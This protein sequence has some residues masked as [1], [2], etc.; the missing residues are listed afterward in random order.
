[1]MNDMVNGI[2]DGLKAGLAVAWMIAAMTLVA[3][4]VF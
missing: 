3:W 2:W 1:M 4:L